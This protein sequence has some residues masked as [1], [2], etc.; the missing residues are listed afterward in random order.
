MQLTNGAIKTSASMPPQM[1]V[2]DFDGVDL[3]TFDLS[4]FVVSA[5]PKGTEV[6][7][8]AKD[9]KAQEVQKFLDESSELV[10]LSERYEVEVVER[11][12]KALYE[13]LATIYGLAQRI[14]VSPLKD[15]IMD[16]V[17]KDLKDKHEITMKTNTTPIAAMVKYVVRTD[18]VTASRYTKVLNVAR[19]E[20]LTAEDLPAY[21]ARRGGVSQ[22]QETE[23]VFLSKKKGDK[24]TK[25]RTAL[26]R[27]FFE[28][29][30]AA[31]HETMTYQG[32]V[33]VHNETKETGAENSS[34]CVFV[35]HHVG[36]DQYKIVT[37]ND[38]GRTFEDNLVKYLGKT[39]PD[40]P[41][42][43]EVGLRN[44]KKQL[45]MDESQPKSLREAMQRQLSVP[46]KNKKVEVI[47]MDDAIDDSHE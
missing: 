6:K 38:L 45:S 24:F 35:A 47:E 43:L 26:I 16:A 37:A 13:L 4:A 25:E 19:E 33:I 44:F 5:V 18:K 30:G 9:V 28:I 15:K 36:G 7:T 22:I 21:I 14:E 20:N 42:L 41:H 32:D 23:A 8:A 10:K 39:F 11:G 31:S 27:E 3:E 40:D 1:A 29:K 34:F 2:K 12:H 46:M 17:R